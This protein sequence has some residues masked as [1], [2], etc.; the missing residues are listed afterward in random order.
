MSF[1]FRWRSK[2]SEQKRYCMGILNMLVC[3][4]S[5]GLQHYGQVTSGDMTS[6]SEF[7]STKKKKKKK[8]KIVLNILLTWFGYYDPFFPLIVM[9][10]ILN[11]V[12]IISRIYV[13]F[14]SQCGWDISTLT[15]EHI[16][17]RKNKIIAG[18]RHFVL[19][20]KRSFSFG[21]LAASPNP[22][23]YLLALDTWDHIS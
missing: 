1:C 16:Q 19:L 23:G 22:R 17:K 8:K 21:K 4:E 5:R 13:K 12:R 20:P 18:K 2:V 6:D 3:P 14:Q 7:G 11:D 10:V 9:M 15:E